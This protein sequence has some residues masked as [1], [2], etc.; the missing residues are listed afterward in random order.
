MEGQV[1][2]LPKAWRGMFGASNIYFGADFQRNY[3]RI[4]HRF[5]QKLPED[6]LE[7]EEKNNQTQIN[8]KNYQVF[9]IEGSDQSGLFEGFFNRKRKYLQH[10]MTS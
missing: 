7:K 5:T 9:S 6:F 10:N 8:R 3:Q 2:I 4:K 1:N